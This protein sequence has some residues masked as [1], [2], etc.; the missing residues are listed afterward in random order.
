MIIGIRC[1]SRLILTQKSRPSPSGMPTSRMTAVQTLLLL[2]SL[3]GILTKCA[4]SSDIQPKVILN[5][6]YQDRAGGRVV[7]DDKIVSFSIGH[8]QMF[9][10][11]VVSLSAAKRSSTLPLRSKPRRS[12]MV[13]YELENIETGRYECGDGRMPT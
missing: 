4:G 6:L 5:L 1:P 12:T 8:T 11:I 7:F 10:A 2:S 9:S 3:L 13:H